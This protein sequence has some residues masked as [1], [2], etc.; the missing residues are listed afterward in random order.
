M[1]A[2]HINITVF[3]TAFII[4][5][6]CNVAAASASD[7]TCASVSA[8]GG[9]T[10]IT[11]LPCEITSPGYYILDTDCSDTKDMPSGLVHRMLCSVNH[12][13]TVCSP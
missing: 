9:I 11:T 8:D 12:L 2:R 10:H 7:G 1:P 5:A 3:C 6:L 4:A 13:Q